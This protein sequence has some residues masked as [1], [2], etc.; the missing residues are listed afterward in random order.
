MDE[1][2]I[3]AI[4]KK[5]LDDFKKKM[6]D[7]IDKATLERNDQLIEAVKTDQSDINLEILIRDYEGV[8]D[9]LDI[10]K[11]KS[12]DYSFV[13]DK[14]LKKQLTIDYVQMERYRLGLVNGTPDFIGFCKYAHLQIEGL[15]SYYIYI[16]TNNDIKRFSE[17]IRDKSLSYLNING[18]D[19][20]SLVNHYPKNQV[21]EVLLGISDMK[22]EQPIPDV[23]KY[24][25]T[26]GN[27]KNIRNEYSHRSIQ[28]AKKE[29]SKTFPSGKPPTKIMQ[30][31]YKDREE[32]EKRLL[33]TYNSLK[34]LSQ[35]DYEEVRRS[36]KDLAYRIKDDLTPTE[37]PDS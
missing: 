22:K 6:D 5:E 29:Y 16:K 32:E 4:I 33:K 15:V 3:R 8:R 20:L 18:V 11:G 23:A 37:K 14:R 13:E 27:I 9:Y 17:I 26:R 24:S 28:T 21:T 35:E 34:F 1:D 12:I 10:V 2:K 19:S 31:P 36:I 30:K 25:Y 7:S